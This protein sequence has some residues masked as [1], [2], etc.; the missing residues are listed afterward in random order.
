MFRYNIID[1]PSSI[2]INTTIID[3][4]FQYISE[5]EINEQFGIINIVFVPDERIQELN[6]TYRQKDSTTDVLSFHY[7]DSFSDLDSEVIA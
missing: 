5:E 1:L 2:V 3:S 4:I 7:Y 6:K